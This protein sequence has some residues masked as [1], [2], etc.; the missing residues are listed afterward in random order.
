[1]KTTLIVTPEHAADGLLPVRHLSFSAI[2]TFLNSENMFFKRYVRQE[3]D[4]KGKPAMMVGNAVHK[5]LE[6]YW[7]DKH[8]VTM[9]EEQAAALNIEY[10]QRVAIRAF[11]KNLEDLRQKAAERLGLKPA[12]IIIDTTG[13]EEKERA[14]FSQAQKEF[15]EAEAIDWGK[16]GNETESREEINR[17]VRNYITSVEAE[18]SEYITISTETTETV[19]FTDLEGQVM[20]LPLK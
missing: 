18:K 12:E 3:F 14:I 1:M 5:A 7:N 13:E 2:R 16:T 10:Y 11:E 6:E 4:E 15:I 9:T 19:Q 20:P 8:I 17:A